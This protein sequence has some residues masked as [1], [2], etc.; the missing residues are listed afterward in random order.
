MINVIWWWKNTTTTSTNNTNSNSNV[1][2]HPRNMVV[3]WDQPP[4]IPII[5]TTTITTILTG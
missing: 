3:A 5:I 4:S 1:K 2:V